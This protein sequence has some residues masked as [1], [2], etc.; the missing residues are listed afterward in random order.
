MISPKSFFNELKRRNVVLLVLAIGGLI[1]DRLIPR[2]TAPGGLTGTAEPVSA[3]AASRQASGAAAHTPEDENSIAVLPFV[4]M[5]GDQENEYF[6]DGLTEELF[7]YVTQPWLWHEWHPSSKSAKA[8]ME[9][10]SVIA[11]NNLKQKTQGQ[12]GGT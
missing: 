11:L 12:T 4:N 9:K 7:N 5:S 10:I 3:P 8:K 2:P 1:A 6:S